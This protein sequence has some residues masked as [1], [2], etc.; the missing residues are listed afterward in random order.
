MAP[1]NGSAKPV[2]IDPDLHDEVEDIIVPYLHNPRKPPFSPAELSVMAWATC[3]TARDVVTDRVIFKWILKNF[4]YYADLAIEDTYPLSREKYPNRPSAYLRGLFVEIGHETAFQTVPM[5]PVFISGSTNSNQPAIYTSTLASA[6]TFLRRTLGNE[7]ETFDTL[8]DLPAEIRLMIYAEVLA[9]DG[10]LEFLNPYLNAPA[11]RKVL[12]SSAYERQTIL[13]RTAISNGK[14]VLELPEERRNVTGLSGDILALLLT[15]RQIFEEAMPVF[16]NINIFQAKDIQGLARMLRLCG[17]RR[18]VHFSRI[19]FQDYRIASTLS[20][21]QTF[22]LLAQVKHL[23]H[24]TVDASD[25][26]NFRREGS[27][28]LSWVDLLCE[29]K[30]QTVEFLGDCPKL[31]A[32][33][34]DKRSQMQNVDEQDMETKEKKPAKPRKR[35]K[36]SEKA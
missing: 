30:V 32:Y 13:D 21:R 8:L 34:R 11:P 1:K 20:T 31:Q 7:L 2:I 15:N 3:R 4:K 35:S 17:K 19:E 23:Q 36:K 24:V 9:Y 10:K 16:Y 27:D 12:K 29:L 22:K 33:V 18:G 5:Y 28:K 25:L 26:T 14:T 6:R